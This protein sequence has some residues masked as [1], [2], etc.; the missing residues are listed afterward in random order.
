M[1]FVQ[2]VQAK[3]SKKA[4]RANRQSGNEMRRSPRKANKNP[5]EEKAGEKS[6]QS[7]N[8]VAKPSRI[9]EID[10]QTFEEQEM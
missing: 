6:E 10:Q 4:K 5:L 2:T 1:G 9:S 3:K 7:E 8:V